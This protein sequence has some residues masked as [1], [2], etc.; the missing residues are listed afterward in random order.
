[1]TVVS[2]D[3]FERVSQPSSKFYPDYLQ[4]KNGQISRAEMINRFPHVAMIGDS[5]SRNFYISSIPSMVWRARTEHQK[6]WFLDSDPAPQSIYSLSERIEK[7]TPLVATEYSGDGAK[8]G[9]D[10][11]PEDLARRLGRTRNLSG[12]TTQVLKN[13]RFPD[14]ILVWIGHNNADWCSQ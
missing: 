4:Y 12:Q 10:Q 5:L 6:N 2:P 8:V 11:A 13:S 3:Y 9:T 7:L 14:L 1:A